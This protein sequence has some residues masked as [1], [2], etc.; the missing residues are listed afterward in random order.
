MNIVVISQ[1]FPCRRHPTSAIFFFNL[2]RE[3]APKV[4][5]LIVVTPRP[6]IP[7]WLA[8]TRPGLGKWF[9]DP[10]VS[11]NGR[12]EIIRPRVPVLRGASKQGINAILMQYSLYRLMKYLVRTRKI[13]ILLAYN[14]I[15][16]GIAAVRLARMLRLPVGF[17][18]IGSDVNDV[19]RNHSLNY[20]LSK[21]SVELSDLV[22][23]ESKDLEQKVRS[24]SGKPL[25]VRTFYKG[26][27][28][29]NFKGLPPKLS[30]IREMGLPQGRRYLLFVGRLIYDKG[31]HELAEAFAA[32]AG[33]YPDLDLLFVGEEIEREKLFAYFGER[34]ISHRI[35]FRGIRP[36]AEIARLMK[37][38]DLLV[39]PTWAE[40]LPN[41]VMEA[42]AIGLP[43]VASNVDGIPEVLEDKITGLSFPVRDTGK[44]TVAIVKML[45]E[46]GLRERCIRNAREL[47]SARFDV[48][49]NAWTL[50]DILEDLRLS[51]QQRRSE[52]YGGGRA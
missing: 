4:G 37:I 31:V 46:D 17:W 19:A 20:L 52:A 32:I 35:L 11:R 7:G 40:G 18:C 33:R 38:S 44:L 28:L 15:P 51:G 50:R 34:G 29:S 3:L 26:I 39:L 5:K 41:V 10:P 16:E 6:Y 13:E 43:V 23:T 48:K 14:M 2:M 47:I 42:M 9:I 36:Y 24:Y 12:I 21:K 22:L 49:K 8:A 1:M 45:E 27:D 25:N 30:L